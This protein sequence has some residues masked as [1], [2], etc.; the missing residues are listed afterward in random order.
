MLIIS[1][2]VS[3]ITITRMKF[4]RIALRNITVTR[5]LLTRMTFP[6]MALVR[7]IFTRI[8]IIRL[9]Q[10]IPL[11]NNIHDKEPRHKTFTRMKLIRIILIMSN[12]RKALHCRV[13]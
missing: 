4:T 9:Y 13:T 2:T 10:N 3:R 12:P 11:Q 7:M 1:F 8:I 6:R 5:M